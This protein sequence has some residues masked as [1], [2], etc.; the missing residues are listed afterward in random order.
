MLKR[1]T[2]DFLTKWKNREHH[3]LLIKGQRQVGKTYIIRKFAEDN[4][5]SVI[6]MNFSEDKTLFRIFK[7]KNDIDELKK[8]I[9]IHFGAG[10][11]I[12][13]NTLIFLDEIQECDD[14]RSALKQFSIDGRF[15]V[16]ASGSLLGVTDY[17]E[18]LSDIP[19][20]MPMG[21]E[22]DHEMFSLD[23]EEFLWANGFPEEAIETVK[24]CIRKREKIDDAYYER[25]CYL[26]RIFMIVGGMPKAVDEYVTH[27]DFN[28]AWES[29]R[30]I[31]D[32][33]KRDINRY[34]RGINAE[35]TSD[36]FDSIPEQL[37][38][39]NKKFTFS[40]LEENSKNSAMRYKE[41]LLWIRNAGYGNF[42]YGL[43]QIASPLKMQKNR[44]SFKVYLSDTGMLTY[45][46]GNRAREAIYFDDIKF[47]A[48]SIAENVV[49][50]NIRK[51]GYEPV[52]YR[53][54]NGENKMEIDFVLELG[55]DLVAIEV[56]SGK[57]RESPSLD[58]VTNV[59]H[60]TRKIKFEK[61]NI[62][63]D[64]NGIEHY[65]LFASAFIDCMEPK[66]N[67]PFDRFVY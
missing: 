52:Y 36:C 50:E 14:A 25:L 47:N 49:A 8:K 7:G 61:S 1:K 66:R 46:M 48:G 3:S 13:H 5:G 20:L 45:L 43:R 15:D 29:L 19:P 55:D 67:A 4:Y 16:I 34:N 31:V 22:E 18:E 23:F 57:D 11:M 51:C 54:T 32:L 33:A 21:Y 62:S 35:K 65:P 59:F 9:E 38:M 42:C 12:P 63:V 37:G 10:T 26:F 44:D 41:N 27:N 17:N 28:V 56:K 58:K 6:Y 53:K 40:R 39:S 24:N 60:V 30:N 64:K 2:Y